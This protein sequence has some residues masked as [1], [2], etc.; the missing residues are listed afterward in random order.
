MLRGARESLAGFS[1]VEFLETTFEALPADRAMFRLIIAAQSWH[2][3]S[4]EVRFSKAAAVLSRDGSLAVFGRAPVALPAALLDHFKEIY[5][6]QIGKWGST[7]RVVVPARWSFQRMVLR[8][9][10][11]RAGGA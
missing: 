2:W 7:T 4:P 11:V 9:R 6:R 8:I 1:N 3:V 10:R 5:L